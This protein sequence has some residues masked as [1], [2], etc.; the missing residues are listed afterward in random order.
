MQH[1]LPLLMDAVALPEALHGALFVRLSQFPSCLIRQGIFLVA[2]FKR[3][4]APRPITAAIQHFMQLHGFCLTPV[5]FWRPHVSEWLGWHVREAWPEPNSR[6][7][8]RPTAEGNQL[9]GGV[10]AQ[11]HLSAVAS[12]KLRSESQTESIH[13]AMFASQHGRLTAALAFA[14][15]L[16]FFLLAKKPDLQRE[17]KDDSLTRLG[18]GREGVSVG[19]GR[20]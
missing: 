9:L 18:G 7:V 6:W 8:G 12:A 4:D 20:T 10:I 11:S 1:R 14:F 13:F 2:G 19:V 15:S 3:W 16:F 5:G 17:V